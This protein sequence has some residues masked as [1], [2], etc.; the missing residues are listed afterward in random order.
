MSATMAA[1]CPR[2][3]S[4]DLRLRSQPAH[5]NPFLVDV[6]ALVTG[7]DGRRAAVPGFYDG[8]GTWVVRICPNVEGTWRYV[9][10]SPDAPLHGR[11]GE[12]ACV[13]SDNPRVHGA[14]LVDPAHPYHFLYEDGSRP[15]VLGYEA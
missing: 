12:I 9:T 15:F 3:S 14:L 13:A 10:E 11:S 5:A 2:F 4:Y 6:R 1:T 7:P 8:D